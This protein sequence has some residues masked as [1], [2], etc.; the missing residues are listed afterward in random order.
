[1]RQDCIVYQSIV[2]VQVFQS[3]NTNSNRLHIRRLFRF[4]TKIWFRN[5][6][7]NGLA[8]YC[9]HLGKCIPAFLFTYHI[10]LWLNLVVKCSEYC[11]NCIIYSAFLLQNQKFSN[12]ELNQ[13]VHVFSVT[14]NGRRGISFRK[15]QNCEWANSVKMC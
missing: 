7:C 8:K 13:R 3:C 2:I 9:F 12:L 1:M 5:W 6:C 10:W 15:C 14:K 4:F 11:I